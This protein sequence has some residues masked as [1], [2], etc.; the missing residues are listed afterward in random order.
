[1]D[2][3]LGDAETFKK[4]T[5][6]AAKRGIKIINDI[7]P[8]HS[9]DD[10]LYF[11]V[12]G[13]YSTVGAHESQESP[14]FDWYTFTEW[15]DKWQGWAGFSAMPIINV[16]NPK[17]QEFF[18]TGEKNVMKYWHELGSSGWRVDVAMQVPMALPEKC[19]GP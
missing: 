1:V 5:E 8:D 4:L 14:F 11:D 3:R 16:L 6:E 12:K 19:V 17:V 15:P 7:T 9:G 13:A 2:P 10:S 18:L